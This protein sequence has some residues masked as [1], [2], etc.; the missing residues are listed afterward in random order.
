M[1]KCQRNL[2]G[3]ST[4]ADTGGDMDFLL[5]K[6]EGVLDGAFIGSACDTGSSAESVLFAAS[7]IG[8]YSAFASFFLS[9]QVEQKFPIYVD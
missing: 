1:L 4:G 7:I 6:S 9:K 3:I 5:G 8:L 2:T